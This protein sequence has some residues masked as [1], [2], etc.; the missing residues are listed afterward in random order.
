M[1]LPNNKS[2][3]KISNFVLFFLDLVQIPNNIEGYLRILRET[4]VP[5]ITLV[6]VCVFIQSS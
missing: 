4:H 1:N 6:R 3:I 5:V 2:H